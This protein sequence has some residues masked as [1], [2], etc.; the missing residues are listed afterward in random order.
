M[1]CNIILLYF[2]YIYIFQLTVT[3]IFIKNINI[4]L[5]WNLKK[6]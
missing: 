1:Y 4:Q 2:K 3:N 6:H 5:M